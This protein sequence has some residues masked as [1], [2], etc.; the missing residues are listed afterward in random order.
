[1]EIAY[2]LI[3]GLIGGFFA[4]LLGI[5]GGI[6]YIAI[7]PYVLKPYFS[8]PDELVAAVIANSVLATFFAALMAV[9]RQ[10]RH[11]NHF[12]KQYLF[13][14]IPGA[15]ISIFIFRFI[16]SEEKYSFTAF[17]IFIIAILLFLLI[18]HFFLRKS[19][20]LEEKKMNFW[21]YLIIGSSGGTLSSLSGLGGGAI[22][23]PLLL[24][25]SR[26]DIKK[27]T[28]ISMGFILISSFMLSVYNLIEF[29]I[30]SKLSETGLI[31]PEK[32]IPLIIGV[33]LSAQIGV[34]AAKRIS[35]TRLTLVFIVFV[36]IVMASRVND[37]FG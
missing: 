8:N 32:I 26:M 24:F 13:I 6:I 16:V 17:N 27:A 22:V 29:G 35:S 30:Y 9:Y 18:R 28:S 7:L 33:V 1:M 19:N 34:L 5:G 12:F 20:V 14:G 15:V 31:V 23:V 4:G 36:L 3:A 11:K 2:L 37:L 21:N 10:Y 25:I